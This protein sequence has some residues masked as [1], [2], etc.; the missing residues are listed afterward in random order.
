MNK[1]IQVVLLM[2]FISG[3]AYP[4]GKMPHQRGGPTVT[5]SDRVERN[6]Q[7]GKREV[8]SFAPAVSGTPA[9]N[10]G[11]RA[12]KKAYREKKFRQEKSDAIDLGRTEAKEGL[13]YKPLIGKFY[14]EHRAAY[15]R[16]R[17]YINKR[18]FR[19]W[20]RNER[21]RGRIDGMR[22]IYGYQEQ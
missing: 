19:S 20:E 13:P 5:V 3:C 21:D 1:M 8:F 4:V 18:N 10:D 11:Y 17:N 9:Y 14:W 12:I 15:E 2:T 7:G 6:A 16:E 22:D